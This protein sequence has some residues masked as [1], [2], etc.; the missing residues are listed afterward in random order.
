[1]ANDKTKSPAFQPF[2]WADADKCGPVPAGHVIATVSTLHDLV[3][4]SALVMEVLEREDIGD[5][6]GEE[7]VRQRADVVA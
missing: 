2:T 6:H 5:G 3:T 7:A 1:M 4:G